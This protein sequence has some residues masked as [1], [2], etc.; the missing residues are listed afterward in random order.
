MG[1]KVSSALLVFALSWLST[2]VGAAEK[3]QLLT[4]YTSLPYAVEGAKPGESATVHLAEWLTQQ[5]E[6]R[7]EFVPRQVPKLRLHLM[8]ANPEWRG[9]VAWANPKFFD[10][11]GR[12][13]YL[14]S[15]PYMLD[16]DLVVSRETEKVPFVNGHPLASARF[17]GIAG[18]LH[19]G[20]QADFASGLLVRE[21]AQNELS[22]LLKL[23]HRRVDVIILQASS[24]PYLR[25]QVPDLDQ[26]AYFDPQP[27]GQFERYL[28]TGMNSPE[29]LAYLNRALLKIAEDP[30]WQELLRAAQ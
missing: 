17:G 26:W 7:Y 18:H 10:D 28:F 6:G 12:Q 1:N 23:K 20:L 30:S 9:V 13:R 19:E 27:Y 15:A 21:D 14:W 8:L 24:L 29:L 11:V 5:S 4:Y 25:T 22:N 2:A 3:M 16:R